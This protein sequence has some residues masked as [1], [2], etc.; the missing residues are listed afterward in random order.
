MMRKQKRNDLL[1]L[2]LLFLC[3]LLAALV[4][5][6][7]LE[8]REN[9]KGTEADTGM[10]AVIS[11]SGQEVLRVRL[12]DRRE[13]FSDPEAVSLLS[14]T[15]DEQIYEIRTGGGRNV[16]RIT[17]QEIRCTEADCPD[18]V[19]V[20]TGALDTATGAIVCLPHRM[21]AVLLFSGGAGE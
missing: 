20:Q 3:A 16:I 15:E 7:L 1:L 4:V 14:E 9:R 6:R 13:L 8:Q 10:Q 11:L 5:P 18:R 17:A 12:S 19:C 2:G 21:T